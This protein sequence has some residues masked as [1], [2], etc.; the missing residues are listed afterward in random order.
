MLILDANPDVTSKGALFKSVWARARTR[1]SSS[2]GR[3]TRRPASTPRRRVKFEVQDDVKADVLNVLP[4]M[5]AGAIAVQTGLANANAR[6]CDV[7]LAE[8]RVDR[9]EGRPRARRRDPDRAGDAQERPHGEQPRQGR[10]R[11]DRRQL[12]GWDTDP[13]ADAHQHLLQLRRRPSA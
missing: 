6:W 1:A 11:G 9:G 12:N 3:S 8:L 4:P 13:R 2:T 5:R 7:E 10:G